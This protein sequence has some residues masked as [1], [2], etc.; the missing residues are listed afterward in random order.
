M[1]SEEKRREVKKNEE[2]VKKKEDGTKSRRIS[3]KCTVW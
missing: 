3:K 2:R 1:E